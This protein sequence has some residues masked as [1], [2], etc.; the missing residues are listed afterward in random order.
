MIMAKQKKDGNEN[1]KVINSQ[2]AMDKAVKGVCD[3]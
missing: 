2:A 3:I 1:G